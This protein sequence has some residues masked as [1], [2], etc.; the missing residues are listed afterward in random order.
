MYQTFLLILNFGW[1]CCCHVLI[2]YQWLQQIVLLLLFSTT[3]MSTTTNIF[4]LFRYV[5]GSSDPVKKMSRRGNPIMATHKL[6]INLICRLWKIPVSYL[7]SFSAAAKKKKQNRIP[8]SASLTIAMGGVFFTD[9]NGRDK[10]Y[11]SEGAGVCVSCVVVFLSRR[12][13]EWKITN[14]QDKKKMTRESLSWA[15][16]V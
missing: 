4:F 5:E 2:F 8:I 10:I 14:S 16:D 6:F 12:T 15:N 3:T 1:V 11:R 7:P 9:G 13:R